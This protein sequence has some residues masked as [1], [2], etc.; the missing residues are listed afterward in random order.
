MA[1]DPAAVALDQARRFPLCQPG[2]LERLLAGAG[3]GAVEVRAIEV[4]TVF[5]EFDDFWLPFLGGQGPAPGYVATLSQNQRD[6][7]RERVLADLAPGPDG[8]IRLT[9]RAWAA[10]GTR[11]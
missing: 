8:A 10:R 2:P 3:L 9:A 1:L 4:P 11:A 5:R 6:D 7:L